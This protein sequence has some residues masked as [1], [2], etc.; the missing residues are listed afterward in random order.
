M[1]TRNLERVRSIGA[2][3][4]IDYTRKDF[5][6]DRQRYDVILDCAGNHS[7]SRCR[8]VL[9][10]KGIHIAVGGPSGRWMLGFIVRAMTAPVLSR[11]MSRKFLV[12]FAKPNNQDLGFL[13]ELMESGKVKPVIDRRYGL[14]DVPEA[15][16]YLEKGHARGKVVITLENPR[17]T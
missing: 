2:D 8:R 7:V 14:S 12:F 4:V 16:A 13:S 3:R 10:A 5:T 11:F 6:K 1:Q 9:N 17:Q 15:I